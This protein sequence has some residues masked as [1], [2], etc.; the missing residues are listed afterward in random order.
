MKKT[1]PE[2]NPESIKQIK[3]ATAIIGDE[4]KLAY[5]I[6][7]AIDIL[8]NDIARK[9]TSLGGFRFEK[10]KRFSDFTNA[11]KNTLYRYEACGFDEDFMAATDGDWWKLDGYRQDANEI[12]RVLMLYI[13]RTTSWEVYKKVIDFLTE[14]PEGGI[15][16]KEDIAHFEFVA[17]CREY[18]PK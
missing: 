18:D 2:D 1:V 5:N 6:A 11:V 9:I 12:I 14:L 17:K 8:F 15:F 16:S 4:L 3:S 13:D 10:K 7:F